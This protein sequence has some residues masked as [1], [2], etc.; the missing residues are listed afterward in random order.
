L[1]E[2]EAANLSILEDLNETITN[3]GKAEKEIKEKNI[4]LKKAQEGLSSLNKEL[5]HK[6][7]ERTTEVEKLLLQKDEFIG[8]LGHDLKNPLGPLVNLIPLLEEK[9]KDPESKVLTI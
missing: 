7:R 2:S 5:E 9:E 4:D 3:L 6:V 8:Q 1:T